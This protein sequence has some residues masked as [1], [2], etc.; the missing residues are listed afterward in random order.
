MNISVIIPIYN[1]KDFVIDCLKSVVTQTFTGGIECILVDDCG[2]DNSLALAEDFIASC[3]IKVDFVVLRQEYNQGPSAARN[4]G[5]REARGEYV[6]FLDADDVISPDCIELLYSLARQYD[7]DYVQGMYHSD[8]HYHMPVYKSEDCNTLICDRKVIKKN[9]L[10]YT[11]I[12]FTPHNRLVRRQ[13]LLEHKL[14]F[15]EKIKVREDFY[16][17]FF[18]AKYVEKMALCNKETYFRGYN[19]ESLTHKINKDREILAYRTLIEDFCVNIDPFLKGE[20]KVLIMDVLVMAMREDYFYTETEKKRLVSL[21][22]NQT[23]FIEK[24]LLNLYFL[25]RNKSLGIKILHILLRIFRY[26]Q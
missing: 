5:I 9:L 19:G 2:C 15:P 10:D 18:V 17:M 11:Y 12:P 3:G 8:E 25:T 22:T 23:S 20:Q 16:W 4:R 13:F 14:F 7:L 6:F 1:A 26:N 24:K 21:F